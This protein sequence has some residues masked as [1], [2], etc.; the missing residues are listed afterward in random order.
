[1]I[2]H[3]HQTSLGELVVESSTGV[4]HQQDPDSHRG[5]HADW[6]RYLY[7]N[8]IISG[9]YSAF[10]VTVLQ[11]IRHLSRILVQGVLAE[12][13]GVPSDLDPSPSEL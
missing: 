12:P 7:R 8:D 9:C 4:G 2:L 3:D 10:L 1:M 5:K 11:Q 13:R 6:K